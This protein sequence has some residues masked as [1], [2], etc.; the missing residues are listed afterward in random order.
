EAPK[1]HLRAIQRRILR[2]ILAHIPAHAAAHGFVQGRSI[3]TFAAPHLGKA[4]VL[5]MD[6]ADFFP[7]FTRARVQALFRLAGYPEAVADCLGGLCATA[8]PRAIL[9]ELD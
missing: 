6:L 1:Q 5:S 3:R 7:S 8:T 9:G 4:V 2:E